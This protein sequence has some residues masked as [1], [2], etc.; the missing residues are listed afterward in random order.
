MLGRVKGHSMSQQ[1]P[2][3]NGNSSASADLQDAFN[4]AVA[5]V[6]TAPH[7][8]ASWEKL[9]KL[10]GLLDREED[11]GAAYR[12]VLGREL[13]VLLASELGERAVT[14]HEEW[15][16]DDG[17]RLVILLNRVLT[18]VPQAEWALERL[19]AILT[20]GGRWDELLG[21]YDRILSAAEDDGLRERLLDEAANIAKN[22]AELLPQIV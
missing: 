1:V 16:G 17:D 5:A 6:R 15:L 4:T 8:R 13:D 19:S 3:K 21:V 18:L 11:V 7:E 22:F 2:A 14:Y 10:G 9:E 12:E 20:L